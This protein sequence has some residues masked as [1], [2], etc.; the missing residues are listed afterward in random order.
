MDAAA[1]R[2]IGSTWSTRIGPVWDHALEAVA[3]GGGPTERPYAARHGS[4]ARQ[5][6]NDLSKHVMRRDGLN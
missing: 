1:F 4:G 5:P 3:Q 2:D 6:V